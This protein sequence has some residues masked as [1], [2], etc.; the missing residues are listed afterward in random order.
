ME[1]DETKQ[2]AGLVAGAKGFETVG[3]DCIGSAT[4]LAYV[5][6]SVKEGTAKHIR[7][8]LLYCDD[9]AKEFAALWRLQP[10]AGPS[11][12]IDGSA[13]GENV[14]E[15]SDELTDLFRRFQLEKELPDQPGR[16]KPRDVLPS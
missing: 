3:E 10:K 13:M 15:R 11:I 1:N 9:C 2:I 5:M 7:A 4:L 6:G 12:S 8:H 16:D 14:Q